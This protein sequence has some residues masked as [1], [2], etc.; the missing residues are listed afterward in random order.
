MSNVET[1]KIEF[2]PSRDS[3]D[4]EWAVEQR[5]SKLLAERDLYVDGFLYGFATAAFVAFIIGAYLWQ[6][7]EAK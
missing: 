2:T 4:I 3:A 7:V 1:G 6:R 5:L